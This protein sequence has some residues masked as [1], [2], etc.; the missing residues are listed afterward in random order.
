MLRAGSGSTCE[1]PHL[2][3]HSRFQ[4]GRL[5]A[6]CWWKWENQLEYDNTCVKRNVGAQRLACS[7]CVKHCHGTGS[8]RVKCSGEAGSSVTRGSHDLMSVSRCEGPGFDSQRSPWNAHR[9]VRGRPFASRTSGDSSGGKPPRGTERLSTRPATVEERKKNPE[10]SH[11]SPSRSPPLRQGQTSWLFVFF[12]FCG[13][14]G[15]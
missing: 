4:V 5:C 11:M 7:P 14:P 9:L 10:S 6:L 1:M 3:V 12:P 13:T 8:Q 2:A 15:S